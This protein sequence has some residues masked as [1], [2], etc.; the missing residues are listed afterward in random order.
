[1]KMKRIDDANKYL[2]I[3]DIS[4]VLILVRTHRVKPKNSVFSSVKIIIRSVPCTLLTKQK[5]FA[6][7]AL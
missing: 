6:Q 5:E 3:V 1:M 7:C 4:I 2:T